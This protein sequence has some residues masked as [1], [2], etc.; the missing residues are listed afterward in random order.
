MYSHIS[1]LLS[2]FFILKAFGYRVFAY[3]MQLSSRGFVSGAG[4]TDLQLRMPILSGLVVIS[5]VCAAIL[6]ANAYFR[7]WKL[8]AVAIALFAAA[9]ALGAG[10][11]E[12]FQK[13][14]VNPNELSMELPYIERQ[15]TYTRQAYDVERVEIK[16]HSTALQLSPDEIRAN[17]LTIQNIRLWDSRPL[18]NTYRQLQEIRTYYGFNDVDMDRYVIN[19]KLRQVMLSAREL[20]Y[21]KLPSRTWINEHLSFTHGY[22]L[23]M[24]PVNR[25]TT[26]G[27]PEFFIKDIPPVNSTDYKIHRPQIYFGETMNDYV[28]VNTK[29]EEFDYPVGEEN[30]TTKYNGKGGVPLDSIIKKAAFAIRFSSLAILLN[31]DIGRDSRIMIY[32]NV[33]GATAQIGRAAK[34][35]PLIEYDTDPYIVINNGRVKWILDGY[36]LS[37]NYPYSQ[38]F[39][40]NNVANYNYIRNSVKVVI[41]AYDGTVDFYIFDTN[42]PIIRTYQKIF[43][44]LFHSREDMPASLLKHIRYPSDIYK[45]QAKILMA[46]HMTDPNVFYNKED[47]WDYARE[48]F[49]NNE[50]EVEPYYTIMKLPDGNKEEYVLMMPF[51]PSNRAN[52]SAWMC[53]RNDGASYG[54]MIVYTFPKKKLIYGPRQIEARIDQDPEISKQFSLW[55]RG[56]SQIIRGNTLVIP[57]EK[58]FL[59]VEPVYLKAEKSEIPELK[60]VIVSIGNKVAME[61]SLESALGAVLGES[62]AAGAKG[63]SE[64][65]GASATSGGSVLSLVRKC[66]VHIETAKQKLRVFDWKGFGEQLDAA[67]NILR[68]VNSRTP[69]ENTPDDGNGQ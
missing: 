30:R 66:L 64:R 31:T 41:D 7:G 60:R 2:L 14:R 55:N 68:D 61:D 51:T 67:E 56:G 40:V 16:P 9:S 17:D 24:T 32:R 29:A 25:F 21:E 57:I 39:S 59:Y 5:L 27:L 47:L 1:L 53:A 36:S 48:L 49:Y 6:L 8:P 44:G 62:V 10:Y 15:I 52:M 18:L 45:V 4:Y 34:I 43:P 37:G 3:N 33:L 28:F 38:K 54:R 63:L 35:L 19:G 13:L 46:Y 42:D 65:P 23:C 26:E 50:Q 11:P 12:I 58:S 22:G 69:D 20:S